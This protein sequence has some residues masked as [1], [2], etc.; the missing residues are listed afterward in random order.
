MAHRGGYVDEADADREN[1]L[2]SFAQ[3]VA[4]G[5]R[6]LETDVHATADGELVAFHDEVL[7]RVTDSRGVVAQLPFREVRRARIAGIDQIPTLDEVLESFPTTRINIDIKA[8][9]A[10][11]PLIRTIQRHRADDRVCVSSFSHR[12]LRQFRKSMPHV[13]TGITAP[14]VALSAFVPL[15]SRYIPLGGQAFQIP[16]TQVV[17]GCR[18]R[19]LT[20]QLMAAAR[21]QGLRIH[22]WTINDP[23]EMEELI[24]LGVDGLIS[25]RIGILRDVAKRHGLWAD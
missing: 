11:T 19:V 23:L 2:F 21:H 17:K 24:R 15:L 10:V 8:E 14:M 16:V 20:P 7:D 5:Y 18:M 3:A 1:S 25:D 22:V 12:R 13:A 9:G 4:L 6:Y